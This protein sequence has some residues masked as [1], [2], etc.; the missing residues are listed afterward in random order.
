MSELKNS[1]STRF[2]GSS[3]EFGVMNAVKKLQG[4]GQLL[5]FGVLSL[6]LQKKGK[7]IG[8]CDLFNKSSNFTLLAS[9]GI[10]ACLK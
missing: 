7:S 2:S 5:F 6:F 8:V 3:D 1:E 10:R 4:W 9:I